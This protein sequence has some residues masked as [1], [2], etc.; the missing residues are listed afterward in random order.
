LVEF[1]KLL[2]VGERGVK[3]IFWLIAQGTPETIEDSTTGSQSAVFE[4]L[5]RQ[6][7]LDYWHS[8]E[9]AENRKLRGGAVKFQGVIAEGVVR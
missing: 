2:A 9:Y 6:A 5:S 1:E 3:A 4:W 7:F 8:K